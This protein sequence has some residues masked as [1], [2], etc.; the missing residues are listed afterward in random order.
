MISTHTPLAGRDAYNRGLEKYLRDFYSHAPCGTW[1]GELSKIVDENGIS[2]HTPL[3]GRDRL[4]LYLCILVPDFYS[5]APCGTWRILPPGECLARLFLLTRPLRDVTLSDASPFSASA[6]STH[7]PLAGRDIVYLVA[8]GGWEN[9]YSHAPCGTWRNRKQFNALKWHF[10]SH[11]PCGTWRGS[12]SVCGRWSRFLLTRPL[13]DVT[14]TEAILC[15]TTAISTHTPLAGRDNL[16]VDD[17]IPISL[18]L[19]TRPL[20]DVTRIWGH[21]IQDLIFLLTRPLRDVTFWRSAVCGQVKISTHTPL[22][23]RDTVDLCYKIVIFRFLLTRP[24][25]DVTWV[26]AREQTEIEDFYSHA[27][28]GTWR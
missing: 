22:A 8:T 13:R 5:H 17:K 21:G 23:G 19:L 27:P 28:C 2:T 11:A 12:G 24:L 15:G 18:F 6:I 4:S 14:F 7:T 16:L 9:F 10:Y 3:A 1:R 26:P 25:R 20:R